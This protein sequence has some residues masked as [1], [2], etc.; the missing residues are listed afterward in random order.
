V[1]YAS[2][3]TERSLLLRSS[4]EFG[5]LRWSNAKLTR[6]VRLRAAEESGVATAA[7]PDVCADIAAWR[8]SA[9]AAL[10]QTASE[11]LARSEAIEAESFVGL[12]EE[13]REAAILH[14]LR[15]YEGPADR[16]IAKRVERLEA[17]FSRHFSSA[18][19]AAAAKLGDTLGASSL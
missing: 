8:A 14:L 13:S 17:Q 7:L 11:F 16:R 1:V 3:A 18:I 6:L 9:Y 2:A 19:S 15:P 12:T 10:P 5:H 4:K